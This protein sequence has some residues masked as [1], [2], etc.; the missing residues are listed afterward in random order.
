MI[1]SHLLYQLSYS[2]REWNVARR[3]EVVKISLL[4]ILQPPGSHGDHRP[5]Y[6]PHPNLDAPAYRLKPETSNAQDITARQQLGEPKH[7]LQSRSSDRSY[8]HHRCIPRLQPGV[9]IAAS[10]ACFGEYR[11]QS[12]T[13]AVTIVDRQSDRVGSH[14]RK[15]ISPLFQGHAGL[16]CGEAADRGLDE[17]EQRTPD[18][19]HK[20]LDTCCGVRVGRHPDLGANGCIKA[21]AIMRTVASFVSPRT[22]GFLYTQVH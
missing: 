10:L 15:R 12:H 5:E 19:L 21:E 6:V 18:E 3:A 7:V 14:R 9:T 20:G 11:P 16:L 2:G 13:V 4:E 17:H 1:N 8:V 22:V